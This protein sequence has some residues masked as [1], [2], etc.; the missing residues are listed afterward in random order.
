[1]FLLFQILILIDGF[2][3]W[4]LIGRGALGLILGPQREANPIYRMFTLIAHPLI[5]FAWWATRGCLPNR[6]LAASA[7]VSLLL[8]RVVLYVVWYANG[9]IPQGISLTTG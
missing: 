9:W 8:L 3:M 6:Y 7:V 2:F 5:S 4:T 1:M